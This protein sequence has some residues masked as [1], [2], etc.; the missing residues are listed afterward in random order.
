MEIGTTC[1]TSK[2]V[3]K[4]PNWNKYKQFVGKVL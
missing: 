4:R 1:I 3:R 2:T